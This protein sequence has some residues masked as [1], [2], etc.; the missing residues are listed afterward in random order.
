MVVP[1]LNEE[2]ALPGLLGDLRA[3]GATIDEVVI[4]DAGSSDATAAVARAHGAIVVTAHRGRALQL[5]AAAAVAQGDWLLFL[6]ADSRLDAEARDVLRRT[7]NTEPGPAAAVFQF[8]I[9]LP[10][11]WKQ[12]IEWGQ[13]LREALFGLAY[14]DQGLLVRRDCFAAVGGFLNVPLMEDVTMI[15]RLEQHVGVAR[16]PAAVL[17]SGRRYLANGVLR[18]WLTHT[19]LIGL[20]ALGV[21]PV[22]LAALREGMSPRG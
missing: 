17:T 10:R 21:S 12:F 9:D 7:L 1:T 22:R 16:L 19:V 8:R 20:F 6:H 11:G 18:T 2:E 4:A 14:G 13:R 5:N 15:R 3:L